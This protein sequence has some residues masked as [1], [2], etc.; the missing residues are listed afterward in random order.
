MGLRLIAGR[1]A[2]RRCCFTVPAG[3]LSTGRTGPRG[4][5]SAPA[6]A[7]GGPPPGASGPR[8]QPQ[9]LSMRS[10]TLFACWGLALLAH[11]TSVPTR[12]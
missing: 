8:S 11:P 9:A 1:P 7:V 6:R 5:L 4:S 3:A 2:G 10:I 12:H